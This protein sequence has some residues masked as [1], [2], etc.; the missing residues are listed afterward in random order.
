MLDTGVFDSHDDLVINADPKDRLKHHRITTCTVLNDTNYV[1]GW[2]WVGSACLKH[3][4]AV[5][6]GLCEVRSF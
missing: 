1:A 5:P 2:N 6:Y 4:A 3:W